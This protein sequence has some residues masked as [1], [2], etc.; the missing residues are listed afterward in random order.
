ME[1]LIDAFD[2]T[3]RKELAA[4]V[5]DSP[6]LVNSPKL[7]SFFLYV[8]DCAV[9]ERPEE[10]TEQQ[11]GVR[12]F[13]RTPGYSSGE[14]SIVRS[15]A[16]LLRQKLTF[17]FQGEG[18]DE[19]LIIEMPKGH[20]LPMFRERTAESGVEREPVEAISEKVSP[21]GV[22][23]EEM[24]VGSSQKKVSLASFWTIILVV[25]A[26]AVGGACGV[27]SERRRSV[28]RRPSQDALWTP[29]LGVEKPTLVIYSNPLFRGTLAGG[30]HLVDP[31][32]AATQPSDAGLDDDTYTGT[33]EAAAI[34]QLTRFFDARDSSFLLK[35]SRLVTWDEAKSGNLI[36]VGASSQNTA[37]GDLPGLTEF[38]ITLDSERRGYILNRH[39]SPGEPTRLPLADKTQETAIMA[40]LP[41]LEPGAHILIFSGLTTIGTQMAVEFACRPENIAVLVQRAGTVNGEIRPFEAVL[42][43]GISKGVGVRAQLLLLHRR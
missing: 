41:G 25:A 43:I 12:I 6:Q 35:R 1:V 34:H 27:W 21:E 4:R 30:L 42:N 14:D 40:M 39:P 8:V 13:G 28:A 26:L 23:V 15:Q 22:K 19:T 5:A 3:E 10:A 31:A 11:I 7:R 17:Y 32:F 18:A 29:F 24:P 20:Y 37:L 33:G 16:R 2:I 36:F 9:R 38:V